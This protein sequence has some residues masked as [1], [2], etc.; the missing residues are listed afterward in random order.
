MISKAEN[1][2]LVW[3]CV[4][5]EQIFVNTYVGK[6]TV[7]SYKVVGKKTEINKQVLQGLLVIYGP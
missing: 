4:A 6:Y 7:R 1:R 2:H 5:Y 3:Q